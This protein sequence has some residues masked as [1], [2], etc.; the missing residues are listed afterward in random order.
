M[1]AWWPNSKWRPTGSPSPGAAFCW[2]AGRSTRQGCGATQTLQR[3]WLLL[4]FGSL[5]T[6]TGRNQL[7]FGA[8]WQFAW[9]RQL[10]QLAR[11]ARTSWEPG[12]W[13]CLFGFRH[14]AV[15]NTISLG[16]ARGAARKRWLVVQ[17]QATPDEIMYHHVSSRLSQPA[18]FQELITGA[19]GN[20]ARTC[21]QHFGD[22]VKHW[23]TL[24]EFGPQLTSSV[25][26]RPHL[27]SLFFNLPLG[28]VTRPWC[29]AAWVSDCSNRL[30]KLIKT[31]QFVKGLETDCKVLGY[32][33]GDHAPGHTHD[34]DCEPYIAGETSGSFSQWVNDF[35]VQAVEGDPKSQL[36]E[37]F[38]KRHAI[39]K[40]P[41]F[42]PVLKCSDCSACRP[43]HAFGTCGSRQNLPR[44]AWAPVKFRRS[45]PDRSWPV[46]THNRPAHIA[47]ICTELKMTWDQDFA[48]Q[49]GKALAKVLIIFLW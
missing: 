39:N 25:L 22:R 13:P 33:T 28:T 29:S 27:G 24:N 12:I 10:A 21:F 35:P 45:R 20:Y 3:L 36:N 1:C 49:G 2:A 23:I 16:F 32:N 42:S 19:F 5:Q 26:I 34:K 37:R 46:L 15:G 18:L 4:C 7:L 17:G 41:I 47:Q 9:S 44:G 11:S 30:P 14:R 8:D 38:C 40:S 31:L 43:Q 6:L 48:K